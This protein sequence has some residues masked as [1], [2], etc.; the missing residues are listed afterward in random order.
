METYQEN[1][2]L[3]TGLTQWNNRMDILSLVV[4]YMAQIRKFATSL[5]INI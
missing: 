1:D 5:Y 3:V 2:F 4:A